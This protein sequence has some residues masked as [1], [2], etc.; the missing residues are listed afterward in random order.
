MVT[1][2]NEGGGDFNGDVALLANDFRS[3][4]RNTGT[5]GFPEYR[6]HVAVPHGS[7]R[8]VFVYVIDPP[9][10]YSAVARDASSK[11]VLARA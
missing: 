4:F 1:V 2:K 11:R 10:G 8:S 9:N 5:A 3:D 6:V 7:E